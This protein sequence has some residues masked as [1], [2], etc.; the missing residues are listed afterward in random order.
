MGY[1]DWSIFDNF[2]ELICRTNDIEQV[3][4]H[5]NYIWIQNKK[6]ATR[7]IHYYDL[8]TVKKQDSI[9]VD[10]VLADY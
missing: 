1:Q 3:I 10:A 9:L 7:T 6:S 5:M 8:L 2:G 4:Y